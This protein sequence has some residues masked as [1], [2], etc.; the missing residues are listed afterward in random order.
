MAKQSSATRQYYLFDIC[1]VSARSLFGGRIH[2]IRHNH[3]ATNQHTALDAHL[4]N[5]AARALFGISKHSLEAP[6]LSRSLTLPDHHPATLHILSLGLSDFTTCRTEHRLV[7]DRGCDRPLRWKIP[8][9]S[10]GLEGVWQILAGGHIDTEHRRRHHLS[11]LVCNQAETLQCV[12][13]LSCLPR[14]CL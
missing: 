3:V 9:A 6:H 4:T 13:C 5:T 12:R 2:S 8:R 7:A 10:M 1:S 11:H 14:L